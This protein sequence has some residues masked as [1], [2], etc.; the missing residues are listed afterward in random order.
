MII[1]LIIEMRIEDVLLGIECQQGQVQQDRKPVA[2]DYEQEGKEGMDGGFGDNVGVE[3]VAEVN[4]V[5]VVT[6]G[7]KGGL[8]PSFCRNRLV[9]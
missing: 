7:K 4:R 5:D 6:A 8:A 3:T 2:I 1:V 9:V